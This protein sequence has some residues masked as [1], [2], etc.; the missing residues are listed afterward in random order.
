[1]SLAIEKDKTMTDGY[2]RNSDGSYASYDPDTQLWK[3]YQGCLFEEWETY[4]ETFPPSG[5][6]RNGALFPLPQWVLHISERGSSLLGP[7]SKGQWPTPTTKGYGHGSEGQYQNLYKK[8]IQG[9]ITKEEMEI[10]T[11]TK[12]ENHRS[13]EK[14]QKRWPTPGARDWKDGCKPY[15]RKKDGRPTQASLGRKLASMGE[16]KSGGQLNPTWVEWLMG[17]KI[18]FTDLKDSETP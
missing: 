16:T 3:T 5:M 17:F 14:M 6:M 7:N 9:Q 1:V 4:S 12:L 10:M 11:A 18:G 8:M 13:Y 2:G 15:D